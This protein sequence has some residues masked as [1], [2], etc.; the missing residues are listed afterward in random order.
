MKTRD[1]TKAIWFK[2]MNDR[3]TRNEAL[4]LFVIILIASMTVI[5]CTEA[6]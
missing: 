5:F 2:I 1:Y 3:M 6:I 4:A